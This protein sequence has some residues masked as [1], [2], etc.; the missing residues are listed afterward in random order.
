MFILFLTILG[1]A[2]GGSS[3]AIHSQEFATQQ[4]CAAAGN[5]YLK[6]MRA[7]SGYISVRALCVRKGDH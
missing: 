4:A 3:P 1:S 6:Q 2:G 5:A 7:A